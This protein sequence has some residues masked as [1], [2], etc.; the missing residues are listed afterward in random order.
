MSDLA[1]RIHYLLSARDSI[2]PG[3]E[4]ALLKVTQAF[5]DEPH[6]FHAL[7]TLANLDALPTLDGF[8]AIVSSDTKASAFAGQKWGSGVS[9]VEVKR[10]DGEPITAANTRNVPTPTV[11]FEGTSAD[12]HVKLLRAPGWPNEKYVAVAHAHSD[13]A[14]QAFDRAFADSTIQQ[15]YDSSD[16]DAVQSAGAQARAALID[17]IMED[18]GLE[19][20]DSLKSASTH[21]L[22]PSAGYSTSKDRATAVYSGAFDTSKA[23]DGIMV[24]RGP[25]AGYTYIADTEHADQHG[26][27]TR[28]FTTQSDTRAFS[29][30]PAHTGVCRSLGKH[31]VDRHLKQNDAIAEEGAARLTWTGPV[32]SFNPAAEV[33]YHAFNDKEYARTSAQLINPFSPTLTIEH[34][35]TLAHSLRGLETHD[36]SAA[37]L[38][39][40]FDNATGE[41]QLPIS[42]DSPIVMDTLAQWDKVSQATNWKNKR[43]LFATES[44][45]TLWVTRAHIKALV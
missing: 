21:F 12:A 26:N 18:H 9:W 43:Q 25:L 41:A 20:V 35:V 29:V 10:T 24:Y 13:K 33:A 37:E 45:G 8:V 42:S 38:N 5:R 11:T 16:Y 40:V 23:V 15:A 44:D 6:K 34:G 36:M 14:A 30:Y 1:Q 3:V 19:A 17:A 28:G 32:Q 2:T 39:Y 7:H 4:K 22:A 27:S 31:A